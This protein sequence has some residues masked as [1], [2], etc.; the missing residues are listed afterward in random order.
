MG[1][2]RMGGWPTRGRNSE[3]SRVQ[4]NR[5]TKSEIHIEINNNNKTKKKKR[6]NDRFNFE[7]W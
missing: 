3:L 2:G 6:R 7:T 4:V 1:M 5:R